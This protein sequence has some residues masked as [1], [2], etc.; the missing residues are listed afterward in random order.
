[1]RQNGVEIVPMI[2]SAIISLILVFVICSLVSNSESD[3]P[4]GG[5]HEVH[6]DYSVEYVWTNTNTFYVIE[7]DSDEDGY[8]TL[9]FGSTK[10]IYFTQ[11]AYHAGH[12][13]YMIPTA[14]LLK[15]QPVITFYE[16]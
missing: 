1:M 15:R 9:D 10:G 4:T 12:N 16:R 7:F 11:M 2:L 8:M 13:H 5:Y 14:D 6:K 3:G